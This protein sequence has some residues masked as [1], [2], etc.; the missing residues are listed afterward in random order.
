MIWLDC[1][2]AGGELYDCANRTI[3]TARETGSDTE[4]GVDT[5]RSYSSPPYRFNFILRNT[6]VLLKY[7][8]LLI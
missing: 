4:N 3:I 7:P 5:L 2:S 1:V 8:I 6:S